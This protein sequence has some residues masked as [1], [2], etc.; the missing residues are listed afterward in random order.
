MELEDSQIDQIRK[1]MLDTPRIDI[2]STEI[3]RRVTQGLSIQYLVPP[4]VL[5]YIWQQGVYKN[6]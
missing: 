2:S 3:R 5:E 4:Q 6:R 1:F